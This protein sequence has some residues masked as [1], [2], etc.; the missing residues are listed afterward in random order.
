VTGETPPK[1]EAPDADSRA[2]IVR[3]TSRSLLVE[4]SAGTG[5]T[6]TLI[7]A[8]LHRSLDADPPLSLAR[9]A[10][11]TFTEKAA[12][13]LKIRL[14]RRLEEAAATST[15]QRLI[16]AITALHEVERAEVTTIHSFC[17]A[18]L[19]ERPFEVGLDPAFSPA[20]PAASAEAAERVWAD[21]WRSELEQRQE[22]A[23][24]RALEAGA[25]LGR[26]EEK[27]HGFSLS[28]LA[29]AL[30][31]ER[32]RIEEAAS[33]RADPAALRPLFESWSDGLRRAIG[34]ARSKSGPVP[35]FTRLV[36]FLDGLA[37]APSLEEL[38]RRAGSLPRGSLHGKKGLWRPDREREIE[39]TVELIKKLFVERDLAAQVRLWPL[40]VAVVD[41]LTDRRT[42]FF[43]AVD[44]EK[45]RKNLVDFDDLL[46]LARDL[47]RRSAAARA[48][49]RSRFRFI[50]VDEFQD[51]DP[52]QM[53]IIFR[54]A[55][56]DGG[57]ADWRQITPEP[58]RLLIVGDPKQSIYRFRRADVEAYRT[59]S[60]QLPR[61]TL[62][63][64][65]R[66]V[67]P[68][69]DWV[70]ATFRELLVEAEEKPYEIG[71][72]ALEPWTAG[73]PPPP[74]HIIYLEPPTDWRSTDQTRQES[75]AAAVAADIA[76]RVAEGRPA[77]DIAVL[78]RTNTVVGDF[79]EAL[80]RHRIAS[81]LEGGRDFYEREETSAVLAALAALDDPDDE[82][83]VYAALKSF[84]FC[85]SDEEL[86]RERLGGAR[87]Q[88][89]REQR[90]GSPRLKRA[91]DLLAGL[92]LRRHDR[93]LSE[94]LADLYAETGAVEIARGLANGLQAAANLERLRVIAAG[95][96]DAG[97]AFGAAL[98]A[99][100]AGA[101][102]E[103]G[104]PRAFEE[105]EDAVRILTVHKAKG[106]E[107][108]VVYVAELGSSDGPHSEEILFSGRSWGASLAVGDL[109][110]RTPGYEW[111]EKEHRERERAEEKRLFY[112][113]AT[114]ARELLLISCWRDIRDTQNGLS[115]ALERETSALGRF[116]RALDPGRH[117][118]LVE[119]RMIASQLPA[120]LRRRRSRPQGAEEALAQELQ[121]IQGRR[122]ALAAAKSL[123]LRRAGGT[124]IDPT[125]N[126]E[127]A[128]REARDP[129]ATAGRARR[130]GSAVHEAMQSIV[131]RRLEPQAASAEA[132]ASWE[133]DAAGRAET[134]DLVRRLLESELY[135]RSQRSGRR[136]AETPV[137]YVDRDGA[138]V[139][140]KID[141]LF[142]DAGGWVVVDYKTT[143]GLSQTRAAELYGA[144]LADYAAA[145][146]ALRP[147]VRVRE[148]WI[149][150]ARDGNAYP[151]TRRR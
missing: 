46:L 130:I 49:F 118:G 44:R 92:R 25:A 30:Y 2:R 53:E 148:T 124:D 12:G 66:S 26:L 127:D 43:A 59:A 17:M 42:G 36:E 15:G 77:R 147:A 60:S 48:H 28:H 70:N 111:I 13:E 3:D 33:P 95:L 122:A 109:S 94:T 151:V 83:A 102:L 31:R 57:E 134:A 93:P 114:R 81:V 150:S 34:E 110:V 132:A 82:V 137:L 8:L 87:F 103:M 125:E 52:I 50:A 72:S 51:T 47:L 104:E 63:A 141:L 117:G 19:R 91:F 20:D 136:L 112:V 11:I 133:L 14:R 67:R 121:R 75:E 126:P 108:P 107:F 78:V 115:D 32:L 135:R 58:G 142:E 6:H 79:Q 84:L 129:S 39:R 56:A 27:D 41:R 98:Q 21:W 116:W 61:E 99:L 10:A 9:A 85:F 119:R 90:I 73:P 101:G 37:H 4:A 144:Q 139:E 88:P 64:S 113:A 146:E 89:T 24:A 123:R 138:L 105:E 120:R 54:L 1:S 68:V 145:V 96:S 80:A 97:L 62:R 76:R 100:R 74:P 7:D 106:L 16:R 55:A 18:L 128:P 65:R 131:E 35:W 69:L 5:K 143:R 40:V 23:L 71:Y 38:E 140:G 45:R 29:L 86:L 22:G 149:L